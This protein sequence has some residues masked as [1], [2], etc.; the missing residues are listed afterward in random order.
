M[1]DRATGAGHD[2][3][4]GFRDAL[5]MIVRGLLAVEAERVGVG[6]LIAD[7]SRY[8][9]QVDSWLAEEGGGTAPAWRPTAEA[10]GA[11]AG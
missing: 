11:S 2:Y 9:E 5:G 4:Q 3:R 7:L 8:E 1:V 10:L 6:E